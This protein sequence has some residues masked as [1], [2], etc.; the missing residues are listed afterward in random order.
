MSNLLGRLRPSH[1]STATDNPTTFSGATPRAST[2]DPSGLDQTTSN[3]TVVR[4]KPLRRDLEAAEE[5]EEYEGW[6]DPYGPAPTVLQ[7]F[8]WYWHDLLAFIILGAIALWLLMWSPVPYR[9]LFAVSYNPESGLTPSST[10][11]Y[12][13]FAHPKQSQIMPII[14]DAMIAIFVPFISIWL[15]NFFGIG[16]HG[17]SGRRLKTRGHGTFLLGRGSFWNVN[18]GCWGVIY[19]VMTGA[20]LQIVIKL[21]IGGLR[22]HF[23]TVCDPQ[24]E[25]VEGQGYGGL[26]FDVTVCRDFENRKDLIANA[27]QSFPSGHSIAA[28]AGLFYVSLYYNAHLKIFANY[29]PSFLKLLLFVAPMLAA[30]LIVGSLTLD[31]SHNWYDIVAGSAIGVVMAILAYRMCFASVWDWRCNHIPLPRNRELGGFGYGVREIEM[32]SG[33]AATRKGGWGVA[34]RYSHR[35]WGAPGD[36]AAV[37]AGVGTGS[38][39]LNGGNGRHHGHGHSE[40]GHRGGETYMH[41]PSAGAGAGDGRA[42]YNR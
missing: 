38:N 22:P 30:T 35:S 2:N 13:S 6:V 15:I 21:V 37:G 14:P 3:T 28:W 32:W 34:E 19:A 41:A 4:E 36:L 16:T 27:M 25:G 29:H 40:R 5:E 33:G 42:L 7:W 9:K 1:D 23:L 39:G 20:T 17:P 24:I 31:M 18:N 10:V 8:K 26:Y 12:P 11:I